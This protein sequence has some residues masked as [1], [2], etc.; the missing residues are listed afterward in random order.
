MS[1]AYPSEEGRTAMSTEVEQDTPDSGHE[2]ADG[3]LDKAGHHVLEMFAAVCAAP[4]D[5]AVADLANDA[6]RELETLLVTR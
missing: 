1:N 3:R 6:L 5:V 4:D 2:H